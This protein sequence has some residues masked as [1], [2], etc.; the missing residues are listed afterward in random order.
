VSWGV[1][2]AITALGGV[3]V[4]PKLLLDPAIDCSSGA[5][6][7]LDLDR[8]LRQHSARV[9]ALAWGGREMAD[10]L[11]SRINRRDLIK[12]SAAIATIP[13]LTSIAEACT[14][15][16][17]GSTIPSATL[18]PT[19]A[20]L[21]KNLTIA[22][23]SLTDQAVDPASTSNVSHEWLALVFDFI[24]G[25]DNKGVPSTETGLAE[26]WEI[27]TGSTP[28]TT[29]RIRKGV[30]FSNGDDVTAEDVKFSIER[31]SGPTSKSSL[32]AYVA[33]LI[34]TITTPDPYTV[35]IATNSSSAVLIPSLCGS[36]N[37]LSGVVM[38]KKY[39]TEKG[40]ANFKQRPIGSGPYTVLDNQIG[41]SLKF[42]AAS[43]P[44]WLWGKQR[45]ETVTFLLSPE[46][47]TRSAQLKTGEADIISISHAA[48]KALNDPSVRLVRLVDY[49]VP[50]ILLPQQYE[51][52]SF[53]GDMRIR[54]ALNL[55][56]DKALIADKIYSGDAKVA[57]G[58][59]SVFGSHFI[60]YDQYK[61]LG[62]YPY[63]PGM[64]KSLLRQASPGGLTIKMAIAP[65]PGA[66][67][68]PAMA[69]A[70]ADMWRTVGVNVSNVPMDNA[71]VILNW[72]QHKLANTAAPQVANNRVTTQSI[73]GTFFDSRNLRS[74]TRDPQLQALVEAALN[75]AD[76][77]TYI[78]ATHDVAQWAYDR[79]T[80]VPVV[81]L[82]IL[83]AARTSVSAGWAASNFN[84]NFLGLTTSRRSY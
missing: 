40:E 72:Q 68:L 2:G 33:G 28:S 41:T 12:R 13:W 32:A 62:P 26:K 11:S 19:A 49:N 42:Q 54:Q 1:G 78:K 22:Y 5:L 46:E 73:L 79:Y 43:A 77:P 37:T 76:L 58:L 75:S 51:E 39:F 15:N 3:L 20:P 70:V 45:F 56:V 4:I 59:P 65:Q 84:M 55:A 7:T 61:P 35:V 48:G 38:P 30:K 9:A 21:P 29:L 63:D 10:Q 24:I 71:T 47:S 53:F 80:Q 67:E 25:V 27:A 44:H 66:P 8:Q 81:Q 16:Q 50:Y 14:P 36:S 69:E 31:M 83:F 6:G 23:D 64:A 17:T 57:Q 60:G 82:D 74:S 52:G 18:E 34:K